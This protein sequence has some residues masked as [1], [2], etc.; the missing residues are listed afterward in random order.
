MNK[1]QVE[2]N[3]TMNTGHAQHNSTGSRFHNQNPAMMNITRNNFHQRNL[4]KDEKS[5]T[6]SLIMGSMMSMGF[7]G[8]ESRKKDGVTFIG[9]TKERL[10]NIIDSI[11]NE[12]QTSFENSQMKK[13]RD[14]RSLDSKS[15]NQ[16]FDYNDPYNNQESS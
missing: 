14:S 7:D 3:S 1:T 13:V 6:E 10:R 2:F 4:S 11:K 16:A 9:H 5:N 15:V 8:P 12:M